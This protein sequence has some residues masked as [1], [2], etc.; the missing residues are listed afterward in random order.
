MKL[1]TWNCCGKFDENLQHLLT[2]DVDVAVVC[3]ARTLATW[4]TAPDGRA[5]TG[6]G[7][8]VWSES[9][10]EL[11]IVARE[12]WSIELHEDAGSAPGWVLPVRVSGPT[13]FT[14]V[15][16]WTVRFAGTPGYVAQLDRTVDWIAQFSAD[17]P[18]VLAGDLNAPIADSQK[19]YDRVEQRLNDLGL[20]DAY[21]ASR[22]LEAGERPAEPTYFHHRRQDDP[23]D[24]DHVFLPTAWA[25]AAAVEVGD[26]DTWVGTGRSDHV[27]VTV[28]V[29]R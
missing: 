6:L 12:P 17:A 11:V 25:D 9:P 5:L 4:P 1:S 23:F 10:R 22:G 20:V 7:Q 8:R 3:E 28:A 27:P 16:V 13:S 24:I 29:Q 21:R 19:H 18:T 2:L 26:F 14:L 15:A